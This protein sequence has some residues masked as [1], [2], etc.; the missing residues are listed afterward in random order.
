ERRLAGFVADQ[1]EPVF[2]RR[3]AIDVLDRFRAVIARKTSLTRPT[4]SVLGMLMLVP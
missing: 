4:A 1:S 2:R 3:E